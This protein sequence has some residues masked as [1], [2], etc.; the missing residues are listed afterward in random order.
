ML[1]WHFLRISHQG[2][3][4]MPNLQGLLEKLGSYPTGGA[5]DQKLH[6]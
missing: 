5:D 3:D 4:G 2:G 6:G 1:F